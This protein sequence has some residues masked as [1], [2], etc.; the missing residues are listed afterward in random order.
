MILLSKDRDMPS[1]STITTHGVHPF[2]LDTMIRGSAVHF[3]MTRGTTIRGITTHGIFPTIRT[4]GQTTITM[5]TMVTTT[6]TTQATTRTISP[7]S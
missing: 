3:I 7:I 6:E 2:I 4:I 1:D 5:G